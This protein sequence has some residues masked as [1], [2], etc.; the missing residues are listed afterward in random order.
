[1]FH[2]ICSFCE[3][4]RCVSQTFILNLPGTALVVQGLRLRPSSVGAVGS[5]PGWGAK[6]PHVGG[7]AKKKLKKKKRKKINL[8]NT[9]QMPGIHSSLLSLMQ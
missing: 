9:K 3:A 8:P 4:R 5:I 6:I 7:T 1:M 2:S